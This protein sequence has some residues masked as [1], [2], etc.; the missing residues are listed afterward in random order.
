MNLICLKYFVMMLYSS[1]S[2]R[3]NTLIN[4]ILNFSHLKSF[5]CAYSREKDKRLSGN[6]F[7]VRGVFNASS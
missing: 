5:Q 7:Y 4:K 1:T 3:L 2:T 6:V